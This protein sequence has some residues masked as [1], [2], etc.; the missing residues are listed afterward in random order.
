MYLCLNKLASKVW[1]KKCT[2]FLY[3]W[4]KVAESWSYFSI[5]SWLFFLCYWCN[6]F[7]HSLLK[8]A[9]FFNKSAYALL[10][11]FNRVTYMQ[12]SYM[13]PVVNTIGRKMS[14]RASTELW[15]LEVIWDPSRGFGE[16]NLL[17]EYLDYKEQCQWK[18]TYTVLKLRVKQEIYESKI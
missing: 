4:V 13:I 16:R 10:V 14:I 8:Q 5:H 18:Y 2:N 17:K 6:K 12:I 9:C 7:L 11:F 15:S 3:K 1:K